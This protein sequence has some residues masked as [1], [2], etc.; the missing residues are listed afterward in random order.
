MFTCLLAPPFSFSFSFS[1]SF[2]LLVFACLLAP[3]AIPPHHSALVLYIPHSTTDSPRNINTNH[4]WCQPNWN[5]VLVSNRFLKTSGKFP[6]KIPKIVIILPSI[7]DSSIWYLSFLY[8]NAILRP[9][10]Y[11]PKGAYIRDKDWIVTKSL[12]RYIK[13]FFDI[14]KCVF[15]ICDDIFGVGLVYL[16]IARSA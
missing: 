11:T 10:N 13:Y 3:L 7:R 8:A 12:K 16:A 4:A 15:K 5:F 2:C 6:K 14:L 1:F 9:G